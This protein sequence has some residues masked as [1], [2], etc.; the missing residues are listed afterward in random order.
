MGAVWT[1]QT[2]ESGSGFVGD[3]PI[4]AI[5]PTGTIHIAYQKATIAGSARQ[6]LHAWKDAASWN[7]ETVTTVTAGQHD[8]V[9]DSSGAVHIIHEVLYNAMWGGIEYLRRDPSGTWTS[10]VVD[11][12]AGAEC[13]I[14]V[15][16]MGRVHISYSGFN[17]QLTYALR[18]NGSWTFQT[19]GP[20]VW[21]NSLGS[22]SDGTPSIAYEERPSGGATSSQRGMLASVWPDGLW[23]AEP[24]DLG[25]VGSGIQIEMDSS[26]RPHVAYMH[27][28]DPLVDY[29]ACCT[30]KIAEPVVAD[31]GRALAVLVPESP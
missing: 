12:N 28:H 17:L 5:D 15:D 18:E 7:I 6:E 4:I 11:P 23:H 14:S 3:S 29:E 27:W 10:E 13:S 9:V 1:T 8:M 19:I 31:A 21:S 25:S 22:S 26:N 24:V 2:I 16:A 30:L 20:A